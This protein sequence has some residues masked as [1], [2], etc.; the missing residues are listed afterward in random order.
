VVSA[1]SF[2]FRVFSTILHF[3]TRLLRVNRQTTYL[4]LASPPVL[5]LIEA[6][7]QFSVFLCIA[8]DQS[9][10]A[11]ASRPHFGLTCTACAEDSGV[12]NTCQ[13]CIGETGSRTSVPLIRLII[14]FGATIGLTIALCVRH[15]AT[16]RFGVECREREG[17]R[18]DANRTKTQR[19]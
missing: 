9:E 2:L 4:V 17:L 16:V 19:T 8:S 5:L 12:P 6:I 11:R 10:C 1:V 7:I 18:F 14:I 13:H 15:F 3:E